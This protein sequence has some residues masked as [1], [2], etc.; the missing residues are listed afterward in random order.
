MSL[1]AA[2]EDDTSGRNGKPSA[3]PHLTSSIPTIIT[4]RENLYLAIISVLKMLHLPRNQQFCLDLNRIAFF[5]VQFCI[6]EFEHVQTCFVS[7][8]HLFVISSFQCAPIGSAERFTDPF[9]SH[10]AGAQFADHIIC[11]AT[12]RFVSV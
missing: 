11:L 2:S 3:P 10:L 4:T 9:F 8:F 7:I 5:P 12:S 1:V 6:F